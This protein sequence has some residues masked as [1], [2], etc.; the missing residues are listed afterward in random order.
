[1]LTVLVAADGTPI[2]PQVVRG[3][4]PGLDDKALQALRKW[5]FDPGK[6]DGKPKDVRAMVELKFKLL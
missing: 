4:D 5:R 6:L 3:L 2:D 1:L